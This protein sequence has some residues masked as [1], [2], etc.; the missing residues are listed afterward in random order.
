MRKTNI[1]LSATAAML[2]TSALPAQDISITNSWQLVG[3]VEDINVSEFDNSCIDYIWK[4]NNTNTE[5]PWQLHVANGGTYTLP[6]GVSEITSLNKAEGFWIKGNRSCDIKTSDDVDEQV[7]LKKVW[8]IGNL[9]TGQT[10]SYLD[11]DDGDIQSGTAR[12]YTRSNEIVTDNITGLMWQDDAAAKN[13]E[14]AWEDAATYCTDLTLGGFDDWELP[15][16]KELLS[17][18]DNGN[19]N[20]AINSEFEN[21]SSS[22]YW[23]STTN[24]YRTSAA[25]PVYFNDGSTYSNGKHGSRYVRCVRVGQ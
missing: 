8:N 5:N 23:S 7:A 13:T 18:V 19:Y 1:L 14:K 12:S 15:T 24:A 20:P 3:A 10:T 11:G 9:A 21:T 16:V 4:Y 6:D 2:I 17:I 22:D 25:W